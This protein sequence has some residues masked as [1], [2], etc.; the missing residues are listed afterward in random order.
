MFYRVPCQP[1]I[2]SLPLLLTSPDTA[3]V[4]IQLA[5]RAMYVL[6]TARC[7]ASAIAKALLNDGQNVH[8][9]RVPEDRKHVYDCTD[10]FYPAYLRVMV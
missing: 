5:A 1:T 9:K 3:N 7:L 10:I 6:M 8:R 4:T 2:D